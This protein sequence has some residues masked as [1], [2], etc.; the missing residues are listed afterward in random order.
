MLTG[1]AMASPA[2]VVV[3]AILI[4]LA[5]VVASTS[6]AN[7][8][9]WKAAIIPITVPRKPRSGATL[10]RVARMT[11]PLSNFESSISP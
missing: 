6:P 1:I 10:V 5:T 2:A 11:S 7:S 8:M 9:A 4:P 3:R